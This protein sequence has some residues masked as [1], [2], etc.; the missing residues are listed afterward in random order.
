MRAKLTD[1][2]IKQAIRAATTRTELPDTQAVGLR[3]RISPGGRA[4]WVL[5]VKDTHGK[6]RRF[7][8]GDYPAIGLA[9]ARDE[10]RKLKAEV[11]KGRD[12]VEEARQRRAWG[13]DAKRG[14]GTLGQF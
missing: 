3:L 12:P 4:V 2:K 14:V 1:T 10:A 7:K 11:A 9:D 8:I 6:A 13:V 5:A